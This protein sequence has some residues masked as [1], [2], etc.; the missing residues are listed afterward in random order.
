M[1]G[2][3]IQPAGTTSA[4]FGAPSRGAEEG[5]VILRDVNTGASFGSRSIDPRTG[6]YVMDEN[7]RL[8]GMNNVRQ[9]VELAVLNAAP[10]LG[11]ID[12]LNDSF[13]RAATAVLTDAC[14]PIVRQG[15]IAIVGVRGVRIGVRGGLRQGQAIYEF[16]WRDLTTDSEERTTI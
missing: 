10:A 14:E 5:G 7:G 9:L 11:A 3:G 1:S 16:L 2:F 8:V 6:D 12:R 13:E 4:G 15:L